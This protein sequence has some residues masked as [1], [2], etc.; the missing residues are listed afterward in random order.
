MSKDR[1]NKK[2]VVVTIIIFLFIIFMFYFIYR[3]SSIKSHGNNEEVVLESNEQASE[4]TVPQKKTLEMIVQEFG[5]TIVENLKPDTC[6]ASKDGKEY[7]IYDDG[8]IV[9]GRIVPWDGS[10]VAP[11][12]DEVGNINIYSPSELKW[13][14]DMVTSGERNF[15]GVTITIRKNLDFGGRQKEDGTWEGNMWQPVIAYLSEIDQSKLENMKKEKTIGDAEVVP[16]ENTNVIEADLRRFAGTILATNVNIRGIYIESDKD[17]LGLVGFNGGI[18]QGITIKKSYIKGNACVGGIAGLNSGKI[19]DCS[20]VDTEI[21]AK[22]KVGGICGVSQEN[23]WIENCTMGEDSAAIS[24][25]NFAG[26]I[27][28]YMNN[29]SAV[30]SS[31]NCGTIK[32]KNYIG[33]VVGISFFGGQIVNSSNVDSKIEGEEFVG[34]I[35]GFNKSQIQNS[36]SKTE[37]DT[38]S[39]IKGTKIVGGITRYKL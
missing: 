10:S 19:L 23:S 29:N 3:I 32:G 17:Y 4:E 8:E 37:K 1:L 21:N 20:V 15:A 22:E 27:C 7:T 18:I 16:E 25:G 33:G 12:V 13:V 31:K 24:E 35:S 28:G 11:A 6:V 2:K 39:Y 36:A 30:V 34:G 5:G 14:S 38:S 9:E 26:G